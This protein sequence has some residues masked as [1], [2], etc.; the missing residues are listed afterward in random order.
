MVKNGF[1][2]LQGFIMAKYLTTTSTKV[3]TYKWL[4]FFC[5]KCHVRQILP[6]PKNVLT[7]VL[8][9]TGYPSLSLAMSE[10]TK[11][12]QNYV[13]AVSSSILASNGQ[14]RKRD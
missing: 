6:S 3:T 10:G 13:L 14:Q 5:G 1:K 2:M 11:V 4:V 7:P 8:G 9:T 12:D